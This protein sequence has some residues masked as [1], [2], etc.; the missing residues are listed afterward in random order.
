MAAISG[1]FQ[2]AQALST[3]CSAPASKSATG[4]KSENLGCVQSFSAPQVRKIAL[5]QGS[6]VVRAAETTEAEES[7]LTGVVFEP[8]AE[9]QS[10]LTSVPA[11]SNQSYA[12]QNFTSTSEAAINEQINVEYNMSYLYHTLFAYFDRDY[13]ALPGFA[14]YFKKQSEEERG[15]AEKFME[16]QN[17]RGGKVKFQSILMPST[18][19]FDH[20][21]KGD[22]LHAMELV[23][24]LEKLT[25]EKLLQ[26]RD[27]AD[28]EN[29]AQLV[30]F[31]ESEFLAE[32]V[33]DIKKVSEYVSQLRR[34][35]KGHGQ[36]SGPR[37][38][39]WEVNML[40]LLVYCF[41]TYHPSVVFCVH[42]GL[43]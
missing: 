32:Q 39:Y 35:G 23:L 3:S 6:M 43:A 11:T 21:E 16:Y 34:V 31:V 42:D 18:T 17:K 20:P 28:N 7:T 1:C 5:R 33:E 30:D 10:Q 41:G 24:A 9:V 14:Q 40:F 15:H 22:A 2:V 26:L 19:E 13:V 27:V 12:R 38:F 8:F 37:L 4:L 36:Y 25:N 29:D